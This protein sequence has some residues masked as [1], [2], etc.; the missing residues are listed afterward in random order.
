MCATSC[1]HSVC[2]VAPQPSVLQVVGEFDAQRGGALN[3]ADVPWVGGA[4]AGLWLPSLYS[5]TM[6]I[7][8]SALFVAPAARSAAQTKMAED[9]AEEEC[10]PHSRT[11]ADAPKAR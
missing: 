6:R 11:H 2:Q 10:H 8:F 9:W 4:K 3:A 1:V 5:C 7:A